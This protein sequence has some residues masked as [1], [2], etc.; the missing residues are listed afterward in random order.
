MP[1]SGEYKASA[2]PIAAQIIVLGATPATFI[3][4][5]SGMVVI[6][7]GLITA[8]LL[9]RGGISVTIPVPGNAQMSIGDTLTVVYTV[10]PTVAWFPNN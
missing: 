8:V 1:H 10:S 9:A 5:V 4:P 6:N 7:G 2:G 3:A